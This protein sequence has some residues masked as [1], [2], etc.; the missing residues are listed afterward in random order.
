MTHLQ[1]K[2]I[3]CLVAAVAL[4]LP[5]QAASANDSNRSETAYPG[6]LNYVEGQASIGSETLDSNSIGNVQL[7]ADQTLTTQNGKAEIL[8][9]PGVFLRVGDDS[10]VKMISPSL[11][12][13]DVEL[14]KGEAMVEVAE[15]H[16]ANRIR[17]GEDGAITQLYKTGLYGFD[18]NQGAVRVFH[19]KATVQLDDRSIDVGSSHQV[20]LSAAKIKSQ[21]FDT[22]N[23]ESSSLYDFSSLRSAYLAEANAD[24]APTYVVNGWY[25]PGWVGTGWYWNPWFGS[26]TFLPGS[27]LLF[28]PFGWGFYSP[29]WAFNYYGGIPGPRVY[30]TFGPDPHAWG[31]RVENGPVFRGGHVVPG[32]RM[33]SNPRGFTPSGGFH[34]IGG[35]HGGNFGGG[36]HGGGFHGAGGHGPGR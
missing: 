17:I 20:I 32:P 19:G 31:P 8:L 27:G 26:Y 23:Y 28:S 30:R 24:L 1:L 9:T 14:D 4:V 6:T 12:D 29:F 5:T 18:A 21:H 16:T 35:F 25:G 3:G 7:Q 10:A 22:K 36:F 34:G 11:T 15:I 33:R 13:T 2:L